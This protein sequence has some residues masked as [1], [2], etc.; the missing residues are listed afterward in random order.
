MK[1]IT[2]CATLTVLPIVCVPT[3]ALH[4]PGSAV[5]PGLRSCCGSMRTSSDRGGGGTSLG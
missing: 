3:E 4:A 1:L 2:G 5:D